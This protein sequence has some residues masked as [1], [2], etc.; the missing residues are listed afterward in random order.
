MP[1]PLKP[2]R[3]HSAKR[4]PVHCAALAAR[5]GHQEFGTRSQ[6]FGRVA[7]EVGEDAVG[8]FTALLAHVRTAFRPSRRRRFTRSIGFVNPM[9]RPVLAPGF[10]GG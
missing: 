8:D 2:Q 1:R 7:G 3:L 9:G 6:K 10:A 4:S 5:H